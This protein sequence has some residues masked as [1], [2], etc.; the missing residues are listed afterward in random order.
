MTFSPL[1]CRD[2]HQLVHVVQSLGGWPLQSACPYYMLVSRH[3][4]R[5]LEIQSARLNSEGRELQIRTSSH[6][7]C[8]SG[9]LN[10][11]GTQNE[12]RRPARG[13]RKGLLSGKE[14]ERGAHEAA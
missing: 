3:K 4:Y 9:A 11:A 5:P 10:C 12:A 1:F 6:P 8:S 13:P 2:M 7:A 14:A